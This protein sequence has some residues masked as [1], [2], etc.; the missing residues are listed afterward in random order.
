MP[1]IDLSFQG[2]VRG[3][4][5]SKATDAEGQEIDVSKW[6]SKRLVK[7]LGDG[8]VFISLGDFL[9]DNRKDSEIELFDFEPA[10]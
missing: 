9:Y 2:W 3:A 8:K 6:S 1:K 7:A 10:L 5:V 4:Q